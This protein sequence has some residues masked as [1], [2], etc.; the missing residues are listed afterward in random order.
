MPKI[1]ALSPKKVIK[2]LKRLGFIQDHITGSHI[3]MYHG[4]TGKRAVIP[5]HLKDIPKGTLSSILREA[6]VNRDE[7]LR[8]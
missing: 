6:G 5:Y 2:K 4:V 1:P 8:A 7:F 3:V